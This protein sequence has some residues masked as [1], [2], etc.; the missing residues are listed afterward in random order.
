MIYHSY[1]SLFGDTMG[2]TNE[3]TEFTMGFTL[4][5]LVISIMMLQGGAP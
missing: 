1:V 3:F 2:F 4:I 5:K